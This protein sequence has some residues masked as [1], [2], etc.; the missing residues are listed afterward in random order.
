MENDHSGGNEFGRGGSWIV[1][2]D[3]FHHRRFLRDVDDG[4][5]LVSLRWRNS[6]VSWMAIFCS[7][8]RDVR[9][10]RNNIMWSFGKSAAKGM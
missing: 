3:H 1:R 5:R 9:P 8:A 2:I 6:E 4:F 10:E 7:R